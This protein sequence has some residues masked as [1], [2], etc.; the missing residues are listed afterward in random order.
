MF[1]FDDNRIASK[2]NLTLNM[3]ILKMSSSY[4]NDILK[5]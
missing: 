4:N 3:N 5:S 2:K 1:Y